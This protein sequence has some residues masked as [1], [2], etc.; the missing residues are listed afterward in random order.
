MK[1]KERECVKSL[2][3]FEVL[4]KCGTTLN[5]NKSEARDPRPLLPIFSLV[6][7][8]AFEG[9]MCLGSLASDLSVF[10]VFP[11]C[12]NVFKLFTHS[13]SFSICVLIRWLFLCDVNSYPLAVL[14]IC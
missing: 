12:S 6:F 10:S 14:L 1:E 4:N 13:L 3:A 11:L 9:L 2:K 5:T 8:A 7:L